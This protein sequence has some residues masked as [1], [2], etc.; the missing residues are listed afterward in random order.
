MQPPPKA[1]DKP[2][3]VLT[4]TQLATTEPVEQ[5]APL[6]PKRRF[7]V[8]WHSAKAG[9]DTPAGN[10]IAFRLDGSVVVMGQGEAEAWAGTPKKKLARLYPHF[11]ASLDAGGKAE[12]ARTI[13]VGN[14]WTKGVAAGPDG[15]VIVTGS[16]EK[17]LT[18]AGKVVATSAGETDVFVARFERDGKLAWAVRAGG[19]ALDLAYGVAVAEDGTSYVVGSISGAAKFGILETRHMGDRDAFVARF[20]PKGEAEWVSTAGGKDSDTASAVTLTKRAVCVTGDFSGV[21]K[22]QAVTL[23]MPP[24]EPNKVAN[25]SNVFVVCHGLSG[26]VLWGERLGTHTSFDRGWD[27]ASLSDGSV[28]VTGDHS[29]RSFVARYSSGGK[30]MWQRQATGSSTARGVIALP[31]DE[32]LVST[33]L[34]GGDFVAQGRKRSLSVTARGSDTVL[35]HYTADGEVLAL[36]RIAG[37][38]GRSGDERDG[39]EIEMARMAVSSTGR[40]AMT[41]R[42]WGKAVFE[43]GDLLVPT[44]DVITGSSSRDLIVVMLDALTP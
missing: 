14:G 8:A 4:T 38:K 42:A 12:W 22:F 21:A 26:D 6:P 19:A 32:V 37:E 31:G 16:F 27:I 23:T 15:S 24:P 5:E 39:D 30:L 13:D 18:I 33:Y 44:K 43:A 3:P 28:V 41:G 9:K 40:V 17:K 11:V 10:A 20:G 34:V 35:A 25:P 7:P 2:V 36:G 29:E 1:S